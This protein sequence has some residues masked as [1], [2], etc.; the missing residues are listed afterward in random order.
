MKKCDVIDLGNKKVGDIQLS[1]SVFGLPV[2]RDILARMVNY[3][4]AKRRSGNHATRGISDV[5]GTTKKPFRQKGTGRA[6]AGSL[7]APQMRGGAIVFGPHVRDHGIALQKKVRRLALKTA[8]ST[9]LS[10][11][12]LI[13]VD[14]LKQA[15]PKTKELVEKLRNLGLSS[16]LFIDGS[17]VNDSFKK[18]ASNIHWIDV[19]PHQGLNVYDILRRETLILTREAVE[20][21]EQRL[22][23]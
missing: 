10:E 13:V 14:S 12:K 1:D 19:L 16:A 21:L 4:L 15:K 23:Q 6:R 17:D 11:G 22:A 9:K 3:Q 2:R 5:S 8:L 7:R 18:A 20:N